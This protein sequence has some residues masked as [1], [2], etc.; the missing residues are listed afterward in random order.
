MKKISTLIIILLLLLALAAFPFQVEIEASASSAWERN[1]TSAD[2]HFILYYNTTDP[3]TPISDNDVT[4]EYVQWVED[5]L[6][7]ANLF[8]SLLVLSR[9]AKA[10]MS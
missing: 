7:R 1:R 8:S 3:S 4:D 9:R 6:V 2:D 10:Y 5:A